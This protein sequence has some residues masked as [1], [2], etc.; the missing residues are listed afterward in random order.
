MLVGVAALAMNCGGGGGSSPTSPSSTAG[1]STNATVTINITGKGGT[2]AFSPNPATVAS[3]QMVVFHN[4]D[5]VTHH[6]TLDDGSVQ[7]SDIPPGGNSAPVAMGTSG[8]KTYHC[9]IHPE[10]VGGFNGAQ[11][12]PPDDCHGAYCVEGGD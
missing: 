11:A 1:G 2:L 3:G 12:T 10:M 7:T 5:V 6:V 9:I 4:N 8:S